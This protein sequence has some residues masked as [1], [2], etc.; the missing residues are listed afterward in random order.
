MAADA[1]I[2]IQARMGSVR[3][4]GKVLAE[5]AGRPLLTV[6][7]SRLQRTELPIVV[8]TSDLGRDDPVAETVAAAGVE[9]F[10]GSELDVLDR[11]AGAVSGRRVD[12]VVRMTADCPLADPALVLRA[13][14]RARAEGADYTSNSLVRTY[15]DGL[16]VEVMTVDALRFAAATAEEAVER[17]HVTPFLYRRPDVFRLTA[18]VDTR[19][20]GHERWTV[21]TEQDLAMIRDIADALPDVGTSSWED[22]LDVVGTSDAIPALRPALDGVDTPPSRPEARTWTFHGTNGE[23][24]GW[25]GVAITAAGSARVRGDVV[26]GLRADALRELRVALR[27]DHQVEI[28]DVPT[29]WSTE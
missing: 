18:L 25:I 14:D 12:H 27:A 19:N 10:R 7:L 17:E 6:M 11:F 22:I 29:E 3:L 2:V 5:I 15:P 1:L 20:L 26:P 21:D 23:H 24:L 4:P 28:L 9:V 16:D 8:A 13:I